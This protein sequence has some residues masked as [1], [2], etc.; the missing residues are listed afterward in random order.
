MM[1]KS[2]IKWSKLHSKMPRKRNLVE[3]ERRMTL[4]QVLIALYND[5]DSDSDISSSDCLCTEVCVKKY[6]AEMD[7]VPC[8]K[9]YQKER[10]RLRITS[11]DVYKMGQYAW[12]C[13]IRRLHP[14]SPVRIHMLLKDRT[15]I[16]LPS[17]SFYHKQLVLRTMSHY[18]VNL[19]NLWVPHRTCTHLDHSIGAN[20]MSRCTFQ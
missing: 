3:L 17:Q 6:C 14:H 4:D 15:L 19:G 1:L 12:M 8:K 9:S 11:L 5:T 2:S 13:S 16:H 20:K 10:R 7:I 18:L